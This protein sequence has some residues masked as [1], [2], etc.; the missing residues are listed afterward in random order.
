MRSPGSA[1]E[2]KKTEPD[3]SFVAMNQVDFSDILRKKLSRVIF[4][5]F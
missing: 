5:T 4:D 3:L 1:N 2:C